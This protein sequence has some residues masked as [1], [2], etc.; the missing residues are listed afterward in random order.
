MLVFLHNEIL[1][2]KLKLCI[3]VKEKN[4]L[5]VQFLLRYLKNISHPRNSPK[6]F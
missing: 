5:L 1:M 4:V 2:L 6:Y 3:F